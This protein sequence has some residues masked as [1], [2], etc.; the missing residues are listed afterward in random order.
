MEC[1]GRSLTNRAKELRDKRRARTEE[2]DGWR[3]VV[4]RVERCVG[5][6]HDGRSRGGVGS[7]GSGVYS[8][9]VMAGW[10]GPVSRPGQSEVAWVVA[11]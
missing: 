8:Y 5:D 10:L 7:C 3:F 11:I 2:V 4:S 6:P 9:D 1:E